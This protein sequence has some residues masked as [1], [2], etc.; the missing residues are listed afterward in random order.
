MRTPSSPIR[1][2]LFGLIEQLICS[3]AD[4]FV[5][6]RISTFSKTIK[7]MRH[8]LSAAIPDLYEE[9]KFKQQNNITYP[10]RVTAMHRWQMGPLQIQRE[11]IQ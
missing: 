4:K 10:A 1:N 9:L 7:V 8:K 6:T 11:R 5:G 3:R 2:D